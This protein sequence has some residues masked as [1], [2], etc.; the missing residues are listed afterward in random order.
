M[1][2]IDKYRDYIV[3]SITCPSKFIKF[4]SCSVLHA[5]MVTLI[6]RYFKHLIESPSL[7]YHWISYSTIMVVQ[8]ELK[9]MVS[10]NEVGTEVQ[11]LLSSLATVKCRYLSVSQ[12]SCRQIYTKPNNSCKRNFQ[13]ENF[14]YDTLTTINKNYVPL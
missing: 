9:S 1:I 6:M 7:I 13:D 8:N 10:R 2:K 3:S 14:T 11:S 12:V 5:C 4:H